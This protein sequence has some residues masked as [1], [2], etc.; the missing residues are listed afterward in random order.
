MKRRQF[1]QSSVAAA[2]T[3]ALPL[4]FLSKTA[5]A[6]A[7]EEMTEVKSDILAVTGD[8]AEIS[9]ERAAVDELKAALRGQL[10]LPGQD[11]YDKARHVLNADVDKSPALVVRPSGAADVSSAVNFAR[12]RNMLLAVKCG[13][14]SWAGKSTCDRGMQIDLSSFRDVQVDPEARRAYAAGG[15]LLGE[16]DHE[17][18]AHGLVTTA[19]TVSHTGIGG[20]T[21]GGGFGRV[22]R[23]FGLALDNVRGV[24]IVTAD[25]Q[26]RNANPEENPDLYWGVRGSNID[27]LGYAD[28][29]NL[30]IN[31]ARETAK[32]TKKSR[33]P[34]S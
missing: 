18:M 2:A 29:S 31:R 33:L 28:S 30:A 11:G 12:E 15:S 21:L 10:L 9:V 5:M 27:T 3:T 6:Q 4:A 16:L 32:A 8:G 17:S 13:G 20:L 26:L 24:Q 22:A 23:R 7:V 34:K 19:G 1:L 25:G 14:H